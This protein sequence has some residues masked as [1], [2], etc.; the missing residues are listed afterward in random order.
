M[1]IMEKDI[2]KKEKQ[3][4]ISLLK[5]IQTNFGLTIESL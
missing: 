5:K 2:S 1:D 4:M 3:I